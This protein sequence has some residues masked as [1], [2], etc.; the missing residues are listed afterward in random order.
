MEPYADSLEH[1]SDELKRVDLLVRSALIVARAASPKKDN[2]FRGLVISEPDIDG[3]LDSGEFLSQYWRQQEAVYP[4]LEPLDAR[5][6]VLRRNIDERLALGT[7]SGRRLTLPFLAQSYALSPA[8]VDLLLIALAPEFEPRYETLYAYLQDDVTR[9]RPSVHLA[10]NLIC[11]NDREKLRARQFFGPC[12]PLIRFQMLELLEDPHDRQPTL[13]RKFLKLEEPLLRWLLENSSAVLQFGVFVAPRAAID[14]LEVSGETRRQLQHLSQCL[15]DGG[16]ARTIVR[17]TGT[18]GEEMRA[19]AE[20]VSRAIGKPLVMV[21]AEEAENAKSNLSVLARDC[22]LLNAALVLAASEA[23][24]EPDSEGRPV[25]AKQEKVWSILDHVPGPV[26]ALGPPEAFPSLPGESV[27]IW[28]LEFPPPDYAL[29]CECWQSA[30]AKVHSDV[31]PG[32]L[33]DTFRFGG[34]EIRK[35]VGMAV[36]LAALRDPAHLA[37]V[38][39]DLLEAGRSLTAANL[40]RYAIP[41]QPRYS[42]DD[43]VLPDEKM[44]QLRN[45][46]ARFEHRRTV[47]RDWGFGEKMSRG[48]G[49]NILFTGLSGVGKTMAA[50]VLASALSLVLYQ[51]DLSAVVSK[52]VGETEKSLSAIFREAELSQSLLFFDEADSFFAKRGEVQQAHDRYANFEVN[53]L[54]QRIEQFEGIVVLATNLQRNIDDAFLRRIHEVIDFSMPDEALRERIWRHHIPRGAPVGTDIDFAFLARQFR[55]SGANIKNSVL[56]AAYLAA[57]KSKPIGMAEMIQGVRMEF[58]KQGK[59]V[60]KSDFG[61]H[62][63]ATQPVPQP[64]GN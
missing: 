7:K 52:Y 31:D 26:F 24:A 13:L 12:A 48:K 64:R 45:V 27:R 5:L 3:M 9:N 54:L 47:N 29:R 17:F 34:A 53:Y 2:A 4:S 10:L 63:A 40:S 56:S 51:I 61:R 37:P 42:W 49:L 32:R 41:I 28:R 19:A 58:E 43:I 16:S 59:L 8:E 35:V 23:A 39:A 38:P 18:S 25:P 50:E 22:T 14:D 30:L 60:M 44:R 15:N 36:S 57:G 33:A 55:F 21:S 20:G 6:R 46:A 11:C 1:L 62:F